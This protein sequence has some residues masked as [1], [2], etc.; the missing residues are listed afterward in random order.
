MSLRI[1]T[2]KQLADEQQHHF[3]ILSYGAPGSGKTHFAATWPHPVFLVPNISRGEIRTVGHSDAVQVVLFNDM[4]DM[5]NQVVELGKAVEKGTV[6]C[7]TIVF[8]N[9]TTTQML[10]EEEIKQKKAID[11]LEWDDWGKFKSI[12]ANLMTSLHSWPVHVVWITHSNEDQMFTLMG[13]SKEFFPSN[14]DLILYHEVV[15]VPGKPEPIYRVHG[16]QRGR[17]V[18]RCRLPRRDD[19]QPF[20]YLESDPHN[21]HFSPHYDDMAPFLGLPSLEEVEEVVGKTPETSEEK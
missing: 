19:Y 15:D 8:D 3:K 7:K 6:K 17:W 10:F 18:A 20:T 1:G 4:V 5:K 11:K 9:L 2:A 14:C 13:Q 16:R 12:F 21:P